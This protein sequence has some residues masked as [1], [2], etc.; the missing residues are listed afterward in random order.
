MKVIE[1][2]AVTFGIIEDNATGI[3]ADIDGG[4][5]SL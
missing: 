2:A 1:G 5:G 3:T 4:E